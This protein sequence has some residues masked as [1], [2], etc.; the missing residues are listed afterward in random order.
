VKRKKKR[1]VIDGERERRGM[2]VNNLERKKRG[3]VWRER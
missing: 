2:R 1:D 3:S